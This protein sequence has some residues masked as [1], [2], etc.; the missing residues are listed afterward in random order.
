MVKRLKVHFFDQKSPKID[1][2]DR[3]SIFDSKIE[4]QVF[5]PNITK[6]WLQRPHIDFWFKNRKSTFSTKNYQKLTPEATNRFFV[7]K[8]ESSLFH[9]K[10]NKN[11]P[12]RSEIDFW[13]EKL[14]LQFFDLKCPKC[15]SR[16]P[17][18]ILGQQIES[19]IFQPKWP[20]MHSAG[21][22]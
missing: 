3:I 18:S 9:P 7:Q 4:S 2:R 14:N 15:T 13:W 22:K 17:K 12:Q 6:N 1:P 21:H 11:A 20:K 16:G 8:I 5:Q 10:I 19:T